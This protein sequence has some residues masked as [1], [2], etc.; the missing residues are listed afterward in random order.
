MFIN[1][2]NHKLREGRIK[3]EIL[4]NL[5]DSPTINCMIKTENLIFLLL[6]VSLENGYVLTLEDGYV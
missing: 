3:A 2:L 6:K 1:L 5:S 4:Y